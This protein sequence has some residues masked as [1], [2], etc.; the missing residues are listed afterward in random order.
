MKR[1]IIALIFIKIIPVFAQNIVNSN[2]IYR[3]DFAQLIYTK[4]YKDKIY[5][6]SENRLTSTSAVSEYKLYVQDTNFT[7]LSEMSFSFPIEKLDIDTSE[8]I[9]L[10]GSFKGTI[11]AD[12]S[13]NVSSFTSP[14]FNVL[15][16]INGSGIIIKLSSNFTYQWAKT[17]NFNPAYQN[18]SYGFFR[19]GG[20][21][22]SGSSVFVFGHALGHILVD[23]SNYLNSNILMCLNASSGVINGHRSVSHGLAPTMNFE[24][25]RNYD[26]APFKGGVIVVG[27]RYFS[28]V[29]DDEIQIK[30]YDSSLSLLNSTEFSSANQNSNVEV[31]GLTTEDDFVY[32]AGRYTGQ[33]VVDGVQKSST[34]PTYNGI[35]GFQSFLCRLDSTLSLSWFNNVQNT[36]STVSNPIIKNERVIVHV[37]QEAT[38]NGKIYYYSTSTGSLKFQ[39]WVLAPTLTNVVSANNSPSFPSTQGAHGVS[40]RWIYF[41]GDNIG[42]N[43]SSRPGQNVDYGNCNQTV[44]PFIPPLSKSLIYQVG[45][46]FYSIRNWW[47]V[48]FDDTIC[49]NELVDIRV[50][51]K[52]G[53]CGEIY[54]WSNMANFG[55]I[56]AT[57]DSLRGPFVGGPNFYVRV[58]SFVS[59][60]FPQGS[61]TRFYESTEISRDTTA[62]FRQPFW[63]NILLTRLSSDSV[64]VY[65]HP[66]V[67]A[68]VTWNVSGALLTNTNNDSVL[69]AASP[70]QLFTIGYS[71]DFED[72][73]V[74][75]STNSV[76]VLEL[77]NNVT[78]MIY[79]NPS[80]GEINVRFP[81]EAFS[82][83]V[84][85]VYGRVLRTERVTG[86]TLDLRGLSDGF[87]N[88]V[89]YSDQNELLKVYSVVI[90]QLK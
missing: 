36:T 10:L 60:T 54:E 1:L 76:D 14:G 43:S 77:E 21:C 27:K 40:G 58:S 47:L 63:S 53:H 52:Y 3:N 78:D 65:L 23:T 33:L 17:L 55:V 75:H 11:D 79:P 6:I 64:L 16:T 8:N 66:P 2:T 71:Y 70:G 24:F 74:S 90:S 87:Y 42:Y 73:I 51:N 32:L 35:K 31:I 39:Q 29:S 46:E 72:C 4:S 80:I 34:V 25:D 22:F 30:H 84:Q 49:S 59:S 26:L 86:S 13:S 38:H 41:I 82:V 85:D 15:N 89:V 45:Y 61:Y 68:D 81:R 57:G 18:F 83:T 5:S 12:P 28:N 19:P 20:I 9:Y 48:P 88:L 67:I 56:I 50:V 69:V 62:V 44:Y 7:V 37:G